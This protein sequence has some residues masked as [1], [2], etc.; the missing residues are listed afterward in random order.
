MEKQSRL[1]LITENRIGMTERILG[2]LHQKNI[3]LISMQVQTERIGMLLAPIEASQL[4]ALSSEL[5][6]I[7]GV[8]SIRSVE[9]LD[10][11]RT[12]KYLLAII[13]AVDEGILAIDDANRIQLFNHYCEKLFEM[14]A[15][16]VV[17]E[18]V[19]ALF[20][21]NARIAKLIETGVAYDNEPCQLSMP[22]S[23]VN[24][25]STGR[26]VKTDEGH[27]MGAVASIKDT[28]KIQALINAF[29]TDEPLA[30]KNLIG[31]SPLLN[32]SKIIAK[33]AAKSQSTVLIRGESGTGKEIFARAIH[34]M[35]KRTGPLV[36]IN[37]AALPENLIESELFGYEKGSFT[38][39]VESRSGL[40]EEAEKGTLFLD[41]IGEL[42]LNIQAKLLRVLQDGIVRRIGSRKEKKINVRIIAA[43]HRNLEE[44]LNQNLFRED[45][46]YR[47]NVL[48]VY[49]PNLRE[50]K[51]DIPLL[52]NH[53]VHLTCKSLEKEPLRVEESFIQ[54]LSAYHWPGNIRELQNTVER[55]VNL[56]ENLYLTENDVFILKHSRDAKTS[57]VLMD[58]VDH[59][60]ETHLEAA[61]ENFEKA[62]LSKALKKH[63]SLRAMAKALGVSHTTIQ[64]KVKKYNI[65]N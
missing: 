28:V 54:S 38:G 64:N 23:K 37:C 62:F 50:R 46:Y 57:N 34:E 60:E 41:E 6:A 36:T 53:F 30:F 33:S 52:V 65:G 43:T 12:N 9:M 61:L 4:T 35:S 24:Y 21:P 5:L 39:A 47:L 14:E 48:P 45:L 49:L 15:S 18:P 10:F 27:T 17:G 42:P 56:C 25:L 22:Q 13:N 51:E 11:E 16:S 31:Q 29:A 26:L 8:K 7:D 40:F 20:G 59:F 1:E 32:K 55:A 3:D 63:R 44:M 2:V 19:T 58:S